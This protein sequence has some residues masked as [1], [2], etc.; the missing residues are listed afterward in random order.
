[1]SK[2]FTTFSSLFSS[3]LLEC[4]SQVA[5]YGSC[6]QTRGA[7]L[8]H[9]SCAPEFTALRA[10]TARSLAKLRAAKK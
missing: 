3:V 6:L 8:T 1:M 2:P 9:N 5:A 4:P 7:N 10:C